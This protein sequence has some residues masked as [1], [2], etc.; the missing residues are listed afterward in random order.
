MGAKRILYARAEKEKKKK[1][2]LT[3]LRKRLVR[4]CASSAA[5]RYGSTLVRP[6]GGEVGLLAEGVLFIDIPPANLAVKL[7]VLPMMA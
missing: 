7:A 3:C 5:R 1:L 2:K 4:Y 6:L